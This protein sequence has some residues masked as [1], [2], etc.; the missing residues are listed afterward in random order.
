MRI[1][2]SSIIGD[3]FGTGSF[4][5]GEVAT[6][7]G[8]FP[9]FG[10]ILG[11]GQEPLTLYWYYAS[12][13]SNDGNFQ[14]GYANY[15]IVADGVGG[16][17]ISYG[18]NVLT[19]TYNEVIDDDP[20]VTLTRIIYKGDGLWSECNRAGNVGGTENSGTA[21]VYISEPASDYPVGSWT[22]ILVNDGVCGTSTQYT[23]SYDPYGT[24]ITSYGDY[25]YYSDGVGS[26]YSELI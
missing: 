8:G 11:S 9:P 25:N 1:G 10:T 26:Y 12:D 6:G 7:S 3:G 19:A 16:S 21:Y 22:S 5:F 2:L 17:F 18:S 24:F 23:Y 15:N 14:Y 20:A 13:T 4:V